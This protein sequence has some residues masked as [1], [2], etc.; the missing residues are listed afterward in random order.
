MATDVSTDLKTADTKST[1]TSQN[2]IEV[3]NLSIDFSTE[4]GLVQAVKNVSFSIPRGKTLSLVGESGSG[5]SVTSLALMRL[6]PTPPATYRAGKILL[7]GEDILAASENRMCELRGNR[8]SMIFQEPMT[9]LNPVYSIGN[10]IIETL[11]QHE[12]ISKK[13]AFEK[14]VELLHKVGIPMPRERMAWYPHHMSGGQRQRAMIAM[15]IACNPSLLIA[16][17]PTTALD[18][19]IQKQILNLLADLQQQYNMSL[20]FITHDLG[21]VA[22]IADE[23]LVMYRGEIVEQGKTSDLFKTPKHP[24][25]KGLLACRPALDKNPH[26]L[27]VLSDFM[28]E[29]G[30]EKPGADAALAA[31]NAAPAS[32]GGTRVREE[33][34]ETPQL[35]VELKDIKTYFPAKTGFWGNVQTYTHAVDGVSLQIKKGRTLGLVGESGCGKTTLGRTMLRLIEPTAGQI[36]YNGTDVTALDKVKMRE[37]RRKM[38]IVFQDPFASLNP[39][40]SVSA[41]LKEPLEIHN[42]GQGESER[43]DRVAEL[44]KVVG[45]KP[46]MLQR[47]PHEFSGG[48]KQ[49]IGIARALAVNPEFIICDESVSALD[50]SIQAQILNLFLDLQE[51][52]NLTYVFISHDLA[53]V[54]FI[55]DD[56]AVM[57]NGKIV[58]LNSA[59]GIYENPQD[60]YTKKLLDAIPK[61]IPKGLQ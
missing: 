11:M 35:L 7:E 23:A 1:S 3:K 2:I 5:K 17:E 61:G 15:A 34:A 42:I 44:M 36:I 40:M 22:D 12:K 21:V 55:S 8:M 50:V 14:S 52:F 29:D 4:E 30:K 10:Q 51:Q 54:K 32:T 37:M 25:T 31:S 28:T 58:E 13:E 46:E 59:Q 33:S 56:V 24:Y 47:Y 53:V 45:L 57:Y 20:L 9:S 39:R 16:D 19:T 49:R 48:Q 6:L 60:P 26:R 43:N 38:Q 27:P 41:I 18:V